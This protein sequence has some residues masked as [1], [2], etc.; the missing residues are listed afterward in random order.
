MK[1]SN[2]ISDAIVRKRL[3]KINKQVK[4]DAKRRLRRNEL[5][6]GS[7]EIYLGI[8]DEKFA[9]LRHELGNGHANSLARATHHRAE[10]LGQIESRINLLGN[11]SHRLQQAYDAAQARAAETDMPTSEL[12][13]ENKITIDPLRL[14]LEKAQ[15]QS[16]TDEAK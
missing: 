1:K 14:R 5:S 12:P 9:G 3:G 4:R 10:I 2:V 7:L 16:Q 11:D 15:G 13:A 6:G 8:I